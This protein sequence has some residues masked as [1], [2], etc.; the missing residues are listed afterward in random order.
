[1]GR[2]LTACSDSTSNST[3]SNQ[4]MINS[5]AKVSPL[6]AGWRHSRRFSATLSL[7]LC[8]ATILGFCMLKIIIWSGNLA[9]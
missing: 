7:S 5:V 9:G 8:E 2:D 1:M 4:S 6:P 3:Q